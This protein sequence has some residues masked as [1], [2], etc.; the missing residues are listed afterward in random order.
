MGGVGRRIRQARESLGWTQDQLADATETHRSQVSRWEKDDPEPRG[1]T[2]NKLARALGVSDEWLE[3][4]SGPMRVTSDGKTVTTEY[5]GSV[6]VALDPARA[7]EQTRWMFTQPDG[8]E[9][10]WKTPDELDEIRASRPPV[11]V[12]QY[13]RNLLH[14]RIATVCQARGIDLPNGKR[15]AVFAAAW[16]E[17]G[18]LGYR[19]EDVQLNRYLDVALA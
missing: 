8:H 6:V 17:S 19:P 15:A 7:F 12:D 2:R 9:L 16:A 1:T 3:T 14:F 4:G 10:V 18:G 13:H 5:G 11:D